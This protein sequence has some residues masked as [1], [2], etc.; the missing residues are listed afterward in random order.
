[1]TE[2]LFLKNL[3]DIATLHQDLNKYS[4]KCNESVDLIVKS[5]KKNGTLYV[6]G[7]GVSASD[8]QH[9]VGE[10]IS[11]FTIK[12][13]PPLRAHAL[14]SNIS[15]ITAIS[16]DTNYENIFIRQYEAFLNKNDVIILLTTSGQSK[17]IEKFAKYLNLNNINFLTFMG[18]KETLISRLSD[19]CFN[20]NTVRTDRIQE[21]Y[22]FLNHTICEMVEKKLFT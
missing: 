2:N 17:N 4:I 15:S 9:I 10:Y 13:R 3:E 6:C 11:Y 8:A 7:N 5:L 16:N 20:I 12:N 18:K 19:I 14:T 1:M 21:I 22:L